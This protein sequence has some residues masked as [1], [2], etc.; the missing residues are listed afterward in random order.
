MDAQPSHLAPGAEVDRQRAS[1]FT[2]APGAV[3]HRAR[4]G[5][6]LREGEVVDPHRPLAA[7]RRRHH[8]LDRGDVMDL[9]AAERSPGEGDLPLAGGDLRP[10]PRVREVAAVQP[11]DVVAA[12]IDQLQ[13][14]IV[15]WSVSPHRKGEF[16][17]RRQVEV[18]LAPGDGVPRVMLEVEVEPHRGAGAP[19]VLADLERHPVGRRRGPGGDR[20]EVVNRPRLTAKR[21]NDEEGQQ[22]S[23]EV[24]EASHSLTLPISSP[25][26]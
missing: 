22:K 24:S 2:A 16:V 18:D 20:I 5:R 13:L 25:C 23:A 7:G 15:D 11:P 12:R 4:R 26:T 1:V 3:R 14:E 8:D 6:Q 19:R 17:V 10:L 9:A 21:R